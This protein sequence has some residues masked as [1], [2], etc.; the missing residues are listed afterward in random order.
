MTSHSAKTHAPRLL[1]IT[2]C[3]AAGLVASAPAQSP[4]A[5]PWPSPTA[6]DRD[7][8]R[9]E[10][11]NFD[12]YL[13]D[14]PEVAR[15]LKNNPNLINNPN[16]LAQ[17]PST[18]QF[19]NNH[20][21]VREEATENPTQFMNRENRFEHNGGDVSRGEAANADH[22]LDK[23]PEVASQLRQNP[24]LIDNPNYLAAHPSLQSYLQ[25]HPEVR[26]D[27]KQHPYAFEKREKQYEKHEYKKPASQYR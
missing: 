27:W 6:G 25:N 24:K 5:A 16:W 21:G 23:H 4:T 2:L 15:D 14:H 7:I 12:R 9:T 20:P 11:N 19:L 13:D 26:Q 8:N 22:Y 3:L 18:K 10:L 17:H 1:F